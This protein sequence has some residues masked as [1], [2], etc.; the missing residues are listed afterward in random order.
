MRIFSSPHLQC[1]LQ[2][3]F[4]HL[5][6][7]FQF[8]FDK[9]TGKN[10]LDP[11]RISDSD[12]RWHPV[13]RGVSEGSCKVQ[14]WFFNLL[15]KMERCSWSGWEVV[16]AAERWKL[17]AKP[18]LTANCSQHQIKP[19]PSTS[20]FSSRKKPD[21]TKSKFTSPSIPPTHICSIPTRLGRIVKKGPVS[22]LLLLGG[23]GGGGHVN[24]Y[25]AFLSDPGVPGPIYG[26]ESL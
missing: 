21:Q 24:N 17:A 18:W 7:R 10:T 16:V 12:V 8:T 14:M 15:W 22:I 3:S 9:Y 23:E 26:S 20:K 2:K 6:Q 19:N 13:W 4:W 5:Q 1:T 25:W 11:L